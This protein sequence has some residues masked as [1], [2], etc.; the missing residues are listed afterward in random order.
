MSFLNDACAIYAL[1]TEI[2]NKL[3]TLKG[4]SYDFVKTFQQIFKL[5]VRI[6]I[7]DLKIYIYILY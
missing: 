2:F 6:T 5:I 4:R 3:K 7:L 1:K